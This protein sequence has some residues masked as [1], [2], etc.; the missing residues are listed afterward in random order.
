MAG[1]GGDER[2]LDPSSRVILGELRDLRAEMRVDRQHSDAERRQADAAWR[3]ERRQADA[4]RQ[5]ADAAWREERRQAD[6]QRQQAD[7]ERRQADAA[8]RE[9]RRQVDATWRE[10]RERSDARFEG[11]MREFRQD[12]IR[13]EAATQRAFKDIRTVGLAIVKTLNHH[14][15]ILERIERK[16]GGRGNGRPGQDNGGGTS[17]GR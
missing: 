6:A 12:S 14:T 11:M 7:D 10:D 1:G 13:R 8:W 5:Q 2:N 9:E 16:L 3:E 17:P 4:E 15:R